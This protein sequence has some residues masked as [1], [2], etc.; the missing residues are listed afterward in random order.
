[1]KKIE[2][3]TDDCIGCGA[4]VGIDPEHFE[5]NID[6]YS[7]V[8]S[9]ENLDSEALIDAIEACPIGIISFTKSPDSKNECSCENCKGCK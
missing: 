5:F 4:C 1:M 2:V 7:I 9:E 6:G 3:L 8:K